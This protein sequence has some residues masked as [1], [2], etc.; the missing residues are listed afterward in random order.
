MVNHIKL[1]VLQEV[2]VPLKQ[3]TP[4]FG[5]DSWE[6]SAGLSYQGRSCGKVDRSTVIM[7][8]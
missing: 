8:E 7:A 5:T 2:K 6:E 4:P 1:L 3:D